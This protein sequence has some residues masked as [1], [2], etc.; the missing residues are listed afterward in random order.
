MTIS[1]RT[2]LPPPEQFSQLFQT[3]G[4]NDEY[5]LSPA[6]LGRSLE[7]SWYA[8]AAYDGERLVGFGRMVS[9]GVM[10]AMIHDMIVAPGFQGQGLGT[11]ILD[12]LVSRCL[13]ANIRAIQLFS[14]RGKREFYE[15][16]GFVVRPA[17]APGMQ[18]R[19]EQGAA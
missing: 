14:A 16:H 13:E 11:R 4:W 10:Y 15:Q 19:R 6:E 8:V 5:Q 17:D 18:Y 12:M 9:E 7:S 2:E 3:T 1:V